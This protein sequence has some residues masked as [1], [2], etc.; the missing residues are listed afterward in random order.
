MTNDIALNI[1]LHANQKLIHKCAAKNRVI[2][3]GKR[4][5]KTKWALFELCQRAG[6]MPNGRFWLI[7]PTYRQAK[8]IAWHELNILLPPE[9][10]ERSVETELM[11]K[12]INGST[13]QLIGADNPDSLRGPKLDGVIFDEA[14]YID[15]HIYPTIIKGQLLGSNGKPSGF[16][17]FIS[18]PNAKGRNWFS[19]F[20]DE[21]KRK[22]QAGDKE[23][24]AF[25]FTIYDNPTLSREDIQDVKDAN[26][27]D[28]WN[29]EYMGIESMYAGQLYSEF[30]T[31]KNV[32]E[33]RSTALL[34]YRGI[35]WG[36]DHPTACLWASVDYTEKKIYIADEFT[37]SDLVIAESAD[38]IKTRTGSKN[39]EWTVIDPSTAKRNSQTGRSD[40]LEFNRHGIPTVMA[41]NRARGY[42]ITKMY[43]KKG[44]LVIHPKCKNLILQLKTLQRDDDVN[45]DLCDVLRYICLRIHDTMHGMNVFDLETNVNMSGAKPHEYNLNHPI[46]NEG[47]MD[48]QTPSW[49]TEEICA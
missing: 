47:R 27:D 9:I 30:S 36:I 12:L 33:C 21:A 44:A 8:S 15:E 3:A 14:A 5:G 48:Q 45:D 20:W 10:V 6:A 26:T 19:S 34:H 32:G 28:T 17:Y 25:Y 49:I 31:E 24:A 35:D 29:L 18:S 4:F 40:A 13:I 2:K 1:V 46:F 37:R 38:M 39:I 7:A 11:K 43:L 23:W 16:A 22:E 42:D 41:D